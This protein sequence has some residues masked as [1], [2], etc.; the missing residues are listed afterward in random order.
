MTGVNKRAT[1]PVARAMMDRA[2]MAPNGIRIPIPDSEWSDDPA[3]SEREGRRWQQAIRGARK[4]QSNSQFLAAK[5]S[6]L[7]GRDLIDARTTAYD[8]VTS[9]LARDEPNKRWVLT[10]ETLVSSLDDLNIEEF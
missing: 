3:S 2:L 8:R 6:G 10:I 5:A 7:E 4:D 9:S 1:Q